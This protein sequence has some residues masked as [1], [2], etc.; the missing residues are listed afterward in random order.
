MKNIMVTGGAG[1]IGSNFVRYMLNKYPSYDIL[2]YDKLT[3]AG[4]LDNLLDMDDDPRYRFVKGDICDAAAVTDALK[5]HKIDTIVNFAAETH[6]DRSIMD[7]DAFIRTDVY[8]T[9]VLLEAARQLG[10]ERYHQIS[11]VTGDTPLLVRDEKT[12]TIAL[13]PIESLDGE[14]ITRY[15]VLT[16]TEDNQVAFRRMRHF[17]KHPADEVYEIVYNGGGRIRATAAHSVFVFDDGKITA[18]PSSELRAGDM[19]ITFLGT[20]D[21]ERKPHVFDL[22]DLLADYSYQGMDEAATRRRTVMDTLSQVAMPYA[23]LKASLVG[24]IVPATTYRIAEELVESGYLEKSDKGVYTVTAE[25]LGKAIQAAQSLRW[26]LIRRKLHIER[27]AIPVTVLLMEAFGRY[28]AEGHC[29]HTSAELDQNLRAVIFTIGKNEREVLDDLTRCAREELGIE[30]YIYERESTIQ[31]TYNGYWVHAIFQQ[32]GATAETKHLPSWLWHQPPHLIAAFFRGYEGDASIKT[33]ERRYFTTVNRELA[34]S[35]VWLARMND[36]NCLLSTRTVQQIK[37]QV[38]PGITVTRQRM[39]Y[40]LQITAENYRPAESRSWR[41]PMARCIPTQAV[42][43]AVGR[44]QHQ[45]VTV[46]YKPLV[47]KN[48]ATALAATFTAVP[49][50]LTSLVSSAVGV[51]KIK[52]IRRIEGPVMV[53]DVSVPNN[54]RFFGGNVPCLLHNTDEVYGH[55][56]GDHRSLETD[57]VAPRSPYAASKTSGD[58]M[59]IAYFVTYG[60]PVTISRGANNIGPYQYPEK[61]IPLF[62]TNAIDNQPLPVYGDGKQR[63]DYQYVLDHCEGIDVVLHK[64]QLGEIYNIGTGAEMENLTMVEILL[65]ELGKPASL[66]QHVEDR[67]GHDRRYCLNVDKLKA[68]GWQPRHSHEEAI[69]QTVRWYV[70]NEWWWRKIK[71]GEFKEYY[72]K[73]Y[74]QRRVLQP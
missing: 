11:S 21:I 34:E 63:R 31:V 71:S 35:L 50:E 68:L 22:K 36:I 39:F 9:Y 10:L 66:I 64:G 25:S 54:E 19:M 56:H 7:P 72:R 48:I 17:V 74:G 61:V 69:R 30:P 26:D 51:A 60:L 4:N 57:P 41:T 43:N 27:E 38:P 52:A 23:E 40:D 32:F 3:Y 62:V 12:Q 8:G 18:K 42:V 16:L 44:R 70:A 13:R 29:S 45:G 49:S 2:V 53:Y 5:V 24:A 58:L 14:D 28:L 73:L 55:I 1:F 20:V 47:G 15:S 37:G 33:D 46:G 67:P 6:V 65:D 59:T